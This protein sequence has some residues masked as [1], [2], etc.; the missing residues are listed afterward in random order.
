MLAHERATA[1]LPACGEGG[2]VRRRVGSACTIGGS[3]RRKTP[4]HP[5]RAS[6]DPPSPKR[7]GMAAAPQATN[8]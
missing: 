6:R 4:P 1:S 2:A 3:V 7:G 5:A 8:S